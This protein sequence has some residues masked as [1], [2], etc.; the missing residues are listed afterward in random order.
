MNIDDF[1]FQLPKELIAQSFVSPRDHSRMMVLGQQIEHRRFYD[2]IDYFS[3]DDKIHCPPFLICSR[4]TFS[5]NSALWV[6]I[7]STRRQ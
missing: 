6:A 3:K 7:I 2:V 5:A 4:I 1:D